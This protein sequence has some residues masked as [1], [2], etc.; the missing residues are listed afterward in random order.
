M[1]QQ[2]KQ[3]DQERSRQIY[4]RYK[5]LGH[6]CTNTEVVIKLTSQILKHLMTSPD[7]TFVVESKSSPLWYQFG[8]TYI[9]TYRAGDLVRLRNQLLSPLSRHAQF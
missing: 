2:L 6:H 7:S 9:Y 3:T 8:Q 5:L 4:A 1:K